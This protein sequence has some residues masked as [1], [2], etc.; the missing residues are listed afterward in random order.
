M[1]TPLSRIWVFTLNVTHDI[2]KPSF[3]ESLMRFLAMQQ[4]VAP[5]TGQ[6]HWQGVVKFLK[7]CRM[8]GCKSALKNMT[9]HVEVAKH[10]EKAKEYVKKTESAVP[11][12][13]EEHGTDVGQGS[14][15][16]LG[17]A[18]NMITS[19]AGMAVV[20]RE[21]PVTFVRAHRGLQALRAT[22]QQ[23]RAGERLC[24]LLHGDTGVGKTRFVYDR[25][26]DVHAVFD[27]S[28]PWFDGYD[29]HRVALL[30]ECGPGMMSYN[31]LKRITDR[32]PMSVP[33]KGGSVP[34]NPDIVFMTSN[35]PLSDWY[36]N[37][38]IAD[39][40]ALS[41]RI[42]EFHLPRDMD[43]AVALVSAWAPPVVHVDEPLVVPEL[44]MVFDVS[45][46]ET[47]VPDSDGEWDL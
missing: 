10:W 8:L 35:V 32:Y 3:D 36:Q 39:R 11:D 31:M 9:A 1:P 47:I 29:G 12:T 19:G 18:V 15:S 26:P 27:I 34:W 46:D 2:V 14:R 17:A 23:A 37:I 24:V 30:D 21:H 41:R 43:A 40:M 6:V 44:P 22:L 28:T 38:P 5:T 4:E 42:R 45:D 7:P 16:D 33:I 13:Y 20:A 25:F